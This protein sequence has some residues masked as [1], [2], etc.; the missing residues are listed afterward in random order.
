MYYTTNGDTYEII[1]NRLN[2]TVDSL[3]STPSNASA[4]DELE[5]GQFVKIPLCHPSQCVRIIRISSQL[6]LLLLDTE[7]A[8]LTHN[9]AEITIGDAAVLFRIRRL[10][11]PGR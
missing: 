5:A 8:W 1:V 6:S 10:Q 3:L 2:I 11:G 7:A 9:P 4:T